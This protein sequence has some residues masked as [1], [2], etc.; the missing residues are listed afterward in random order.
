LARFEIALYAASVDKP[1][2]NLR[3]AD[4][5]GLSYPI[6]SDP[7]KQSA[8]AYGV[9]RIGMF[10]QRKTFVIDRD[11]LIAHVVT[12][13]SVNTAGEDLVRLLDELGVPKN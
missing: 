1:K 13:V 3:F 11:G 6:L 10:A 2:A 7:G 4:S 9:L 8:R 12:K 5:L